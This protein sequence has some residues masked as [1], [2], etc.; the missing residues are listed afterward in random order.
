[1]ADADPDFVPSPLAD[2]RNGLPISLSRYLGPIW[3][4]TYKYSSGPD[5]GAGWQP[6]EVAGEYHGSEKQLKTS[7]EIK[8]QDQSYLFEMERSL[9]YW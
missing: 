4:K 5:T 7:M 8:T 2:A 3:V 6:M 9:I 1:M